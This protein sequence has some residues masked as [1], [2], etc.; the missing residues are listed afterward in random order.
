[1]TF[2]EIKQNIFA[3]YAIQNHIDDYINHYVPIIDHV[4]EMIG[5]S[6]AEE[7][8]SYYIENF[9]K[10]SRQYLFDKIKNQEEFIGCLVFNYT[11]NENGKDEF[12]F[13]SNPDSNKKSAVIKTSRNEVGNFI[14]SIKKDI[15][16]DIKNSDK[17]YSSFGTNITIA[18]KFQKL[19]PG[20]K[21]NYQDKSYQYCMILRNHISDVNKIIL[22]YKINL[23]RIIDDLDILIT[24]NFHK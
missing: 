2:A 23:G 14:S 17:L 7:M 11:K 6:T 13:Q 9:N 20:R 8:E 5:K 21:I 4:F 22:D 16:I 19:Y 12:S 15:L 24:F 18:E 1:M 3:Y 10:I